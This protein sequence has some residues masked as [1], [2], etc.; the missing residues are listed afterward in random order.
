[1]PF[2]VAEVKMTLKILTTRNLAPSWPLWLAKR[3]ERERRDVMRTALDAGI[4]K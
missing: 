4:V 1:M 2:Y 3:V